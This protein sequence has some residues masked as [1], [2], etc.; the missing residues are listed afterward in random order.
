[1]SAR[2]LPRWAVVLV[3]VSCCFALLGIG[4]A[5]FSVLGGGGG[6][7]PLAGIVEVSDDG[8]APM[9]DEA[10]RAVT[11]V[12]PA[13]TAK[14]QAAGDRVVVLPSRVA[15]S[16][17]QTL[18]LRNDDDRAVVIGP[19]FVGPGE[20]STYRFSSPRVIAGACDLHPSGEFTVEVTA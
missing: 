17:G 15:I 19:F 14:R 18:H 4:V 10:T 11:F 5:A 9:V 1:M 16:V 12:I 13:G 3:A 8:P 7:D 2:R 6:A 20:T